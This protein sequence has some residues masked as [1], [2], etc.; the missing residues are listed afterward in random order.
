MSVRTTQASRFFPAAKAQEWAK[1]DKAAGVFTQKAGETAQLLGDMTS[2]ALRLYRATEN[3]AIQS[4]GDA[5]KKGQEQAKQLRQA[6]ASSLEQAV[7]G[8]KVVEEHRAESMELSS[9]GTVARS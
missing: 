5:T 2:H 7:V 6:K 9:Q 8:Q 4:F 3:E 1:D